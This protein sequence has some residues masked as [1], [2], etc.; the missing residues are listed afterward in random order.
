MKPRIHHIAVFTAALSF[1][2]FVIFIARREAPPEEIHVETHEKQMIKNF[3][4]N[5]PEKGNKWLLKSPE[6]VFERENVLLLKSPKLVL[7]DRGNATIEAETAIFKQEE[8]KLFLKNVRVKGKNFFAMAENGVYNT[9]SEVF[10]TKRW[11]R[12]LLRN[13][14]RI[15]GKRCTLDLK[16][17]RVIIHSKVR[18]VVLGR[19]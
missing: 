13:K 8:G 11:C 1:L 9:K 10:K 6:A 5:S 15:R 2:P 3:T 12:L 19:R 4:L 16:N 17:R 14:H 18:S 7:L